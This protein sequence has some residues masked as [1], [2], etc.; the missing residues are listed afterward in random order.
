MGDFLLR[1]VKINLINS[2]NP[3]LKGKALTTNLKGIWRYRIMNYRL[4]V[5][6]KE[7][8]FIIKALSIGHRREIYN[9]K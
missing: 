6:I 2:T 5:E 8:K 1:F 9:L 7:E 3:F 4:L